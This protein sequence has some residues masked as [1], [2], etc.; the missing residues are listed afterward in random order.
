MVGDR[1]LNLN[2]TIDIFKSK[3]EITEEKTFEIKKI[4]F[5]SKMK[6]I[7][8]IAGFSLIIIGYYISSYFLAENIFSTSSQNF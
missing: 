6:K 2:N 4:Y 1:T 3:E 7:F 5:M 8:S